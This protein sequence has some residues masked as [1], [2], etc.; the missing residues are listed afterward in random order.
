[1]FRRVGLVQKCVMS[2]SEEIS[3]KIEFI[4]MNALGWKAH[5][6]LALWGEPGGSREEPSRL[7]TFITNGCVP[8][9]EQ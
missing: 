2:K 8:T 1:M 5:S 9:K 6:P 3:H 7:V 4:Q